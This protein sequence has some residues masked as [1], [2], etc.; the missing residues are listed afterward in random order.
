MESIRLIT[1]DYEMII[2][3]HGNFT[4]VVSHSNVLKLEVKAVVEG[5]EKKEGEPEA[6]K[7]A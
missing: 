5:G 2:A 4:L 6:K 7:E 1:K 3:Q